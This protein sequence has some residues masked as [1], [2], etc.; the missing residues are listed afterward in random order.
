LRKILAAAVVLAVPVIGALA[1]SASAYC[2]PK[3]YPLCTND[4]QQAPTDV[5]QLLHDPFGTLIRA[6]PE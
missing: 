2:D 1:P 4:C 6:C 3:Y 5:K